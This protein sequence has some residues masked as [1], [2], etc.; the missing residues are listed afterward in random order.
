M[1]DDKPGRKLLWWNMPISTDDRA[2]VGRKMINTIAIWIAVIAALVA[3]LF[4][5]RII[6]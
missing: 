4:I 5:V 2:D 6:L 3:I 1:S